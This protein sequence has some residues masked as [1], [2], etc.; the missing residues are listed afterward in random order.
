MRLDYYQGLATFYSENT[1]LRDSLS[2][3]AFDPKTGVIADNEAYAELTRI[4]TSIK[5]LTLVNYHN[6]HFS[7]SYHEATA[8]FNGT[9]E[10]SLPQWTITDEVATASGYPARKAEGYYL[11]RHWT[12]WYTEDIPVNCGP[13]LLWGAPGL[14]VYAMDSEELIC[15][16]LSGVEK[17]QDN[18][19]AAFLKEYYESNTSKP[20]IIWDSSKHCLAGK[21]RPPRKREKTPKPATSTC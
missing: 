17:L 7:Q 1:Y 18:R 6:G 14:I 16:K 10:V 13:W 11:G 3:I 9:G 2:V 20:T 15:F 19:R 12:I 4:P 5:D 8:F 21:R